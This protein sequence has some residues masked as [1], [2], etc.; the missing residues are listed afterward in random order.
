MRAVTVQR[1]IPNS[2]RTGPCPPGPYA[3]ARVVGKEKEKAVCVHGAA[4]GTFP[5]HLCWIFLEMQSTL[6]DLEI[7]TDLPVCISF[8][9]R[10]GRQIQAAGQLPWAPHKPG[11][12]PVKIELPHATGSCEPH[13][14]LSSPPI[15]G[16]CLLPCSLWAVREVCRFTSRRREGEGPVKVRLAAVWVEGRD[17]PWQ[18][19]V[20][21]FKTCPWQGGQGALRRAT[22]PELHGMECC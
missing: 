15:P 12:S 19:A 11:T 22:S 10:S 16:P 7:D 1:V 3:A 5:D 6:E 17:A 18:T 9:L 21:S 14:P 4:E 13:P 8:S 2:G 20:P